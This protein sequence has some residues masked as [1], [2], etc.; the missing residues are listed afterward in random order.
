[1]PHDKFKFVDSG[2]KI[3]LDLIFD[4]LSL[5]TGCFM[6]YAMS[7]LRLLGTKSIS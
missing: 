5:N 2:L 4:N 1:M 3:A 6:D 7:L